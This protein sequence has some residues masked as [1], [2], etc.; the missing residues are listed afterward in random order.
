MPKV[1]LISDM[2]FGHRNIM[3]Y[4]NRPFDNV[5]DMD[6]AIINNWNQVVDKGD[7]IFILG[8][9]S[10]YNKDK[11]TDIIK[12]LNGYK[13]LILGNHDRDR[14]LNWWKDTG[15][16]E[17]SKYPIIYDEFYIFSHEPLYLNENMP[18][19]N[20]HGHTHHLRYDSRQ[21]FN[22][23]VECINYTPIEFE[24]IRNVIQGKSE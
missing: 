2:H 13:M 4:E 1:F 3:K 6:M 20:I 22:V 21:F 16:D 11:T 18:Y 14:S 5:D 12:M 19:A 8:D 7:K 9:V 23:S 24:K 15:I 10:F 17:I